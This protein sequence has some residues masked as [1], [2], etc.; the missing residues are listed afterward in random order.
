MTDLH[1]VARGRTHQADVKVEVGGLRQAAVVNSAS[2]RRP[3]QQLQRVCTEQV[4]MLKPWQSCSRRVQA[5]SSIP[6]EA[7][8]R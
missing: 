7:L 6:C 4:E 1:L 5:G 3:H 2:W 8:H